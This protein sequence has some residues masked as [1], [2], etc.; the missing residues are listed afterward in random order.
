VSLRD[1]FPP[2][3]EC[4]SCGAPVK[5]TPLADAEPLKEWACEHTTAPIWANRKVT[6]R[7]KG[8]LEAMN[9]VQRGVIRIKL[10]LRQFLSALTGRSI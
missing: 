2:L 3:Y 1:R 5:V 10:T 6:L 9:P 4:S 7:G 8:E